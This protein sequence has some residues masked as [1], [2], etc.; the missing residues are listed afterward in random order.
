M[1]KT[2]LFPSKRGMLIEQIHVAL[3]GKSK[4]LFKQKAL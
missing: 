4:P 1:K 2:F 3:T